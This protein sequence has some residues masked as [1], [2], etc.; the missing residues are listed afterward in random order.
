M[1]FDAA[2]FPPRPDQPRRAARDDNV[3]CLIVIILAFCMLVMP[4]SMAAFVDIV[5]CLRGH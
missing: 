5:R 4:I 1:P 2:G 3:A